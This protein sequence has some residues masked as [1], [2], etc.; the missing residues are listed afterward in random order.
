MD[1]SLHENGREEKEVKQV[2][3]KKYIPLLL[4]VDH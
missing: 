3:D 4:P 1:E 2:G